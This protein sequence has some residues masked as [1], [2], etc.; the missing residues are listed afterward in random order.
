MNVVGFLLP[1]LF[2]IAV[3]VV[4]VVWALSL[5]WRL[6]E[7]YGL[8]LITKPDPR[9]P[10]LE[11]VFAAR[12]LVRLGVLVE[13]SWT[14]IAI[15]L[16]MRLAP[17]MGTV[18]RVLWLLIEMIVIIVVFATLLHLEKLAGRIPRDRWAQWLCVLRWTLCS[19]LALGFIQDV[20]AFFAGPFGPS[21]SWRILG[22][23]MIV[24]TIVR[25]AIHLPY[26]VLLWKLGTAFRKQADLARQS[27][28][29]ADR[30]S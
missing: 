9:G 23:M 16:G 7:W 5:A 2:G 20:A 12:R 3:G 17:G 18:V 15:F 4:G 1:L 8:W 28:G 6:L 22:R 19:V 30:D 10:V 14:A 26:L 11:A 13:I 29:M 24:T 27:W 25:A 21:L